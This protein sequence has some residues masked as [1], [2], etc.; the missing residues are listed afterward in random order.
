MTSE[1][2]TSPLISKAYTYLEDG[3][4]NSANHLI[5]TYL[6]RHPEDGQAHHMAGLCRDALGDRE[7][8]RHH[9]EQSVALSPAETGP[10]IQLFMFLA[11]DDD[12]DSAL[13][14]VEKALRH[15]P[16]NAR[17]LQARSNAQRQLGDIKG[18][19]TTANMA[20][21][22]K[23]S[24]AYAHYTLGMSLT[25]ARLYKE[26][27]DAFRSAVELDST[28]ADAWTNLGVVEKE[29]GD[30][31]AATLSYENALTL[32]PNDPIIHNNQGNMLLACGDVSSAMSAYRR[33]VELKPD[34]VDAKVNLALAYREQGDPEHA[35]KYLEEIDREH[36]NEASVLNSL[37]NALRHAERFEEARTALECAINLSPDHAEAHNNLGLVMALLGRRDE[38]RTFFSK[39]EKL[40]PDL[41]VFANN[42][43]TLLLKMFHLDDAILAL[44]RAVLLDP[45][46]CDAW[47]NLGVAHFMCGH[48][49]EAVDAYRK[50]I[51]QQPDNT[52]AHYSLGV[53]LIEQQ[54]LSEGT[55]EI[56]R[57]LELNPNNVM[58]LNT[59]G[60]ALLD[61]HCIDDARAAMKTAAES[62]T[63]SAPVYASNYLFTS[64][65]SPDV[66][67]QQI[68]EE[69]SAF[70]KRFTS[71]TPDRNY[72]HLN[73]SNPDRKLKLAYLSP[74]FRSHSV[75]FFIEPLLEKHDRNA[76]EIILYSN[77]T[78]QDVVTQAMQGAA[79]VWVET[80]GLTDQNLVERIRADRV[81]ILV[82]LGGHTSGN[83]LVACGQKPVPIQIQYL[84]Y[85]NTSGVQAMDY[86]LSDERADPTG[87][88]KVFCTETIIRLPDCFHC[89][90]P[91]SRA[92][93]PASA[94]HVER[95]FV[96][97]G[98]FN[99]LP[100][101]NTEVVN[102]WSEILTQVPNSR[103]YL[104]CK[105]LKTE[106]VRDRVMGYF[107]D[108]GIDKSRIDMDAFMPS[109]QEH[110]NQYARIDL[111]LDT[112]PYN[113]TTTTCEALWMGVPV[114]SV[115]GTRHTG[116]V[117]L[118]L[119]HAAGLSEEFIAKDLK[120]YIQKA[121]SWGHS[122]QRLAEVRSTL[123][124][125]LS[126]S[127][128]RDEIRF[129]RNLERVYRD[130]WRQW[131][132]GPQQTYEHK[133]P[134]PL[135]A[136]DSVQSVLGKTL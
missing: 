1:T 59:L 14:I 60:V 135:R 120:T 77:T 97:F 100:K 22:F 62:D 53:A 49:E 19:I 65:Y 90:R 63:M 71:N 68:F 106:S 112:F 10:A 34:Y 125:Q 86:R 3:D 107:V 128:L 136:D 110:L 38:A 87:E 74:D 17:L 44:E 124:Q 28:F 54:D 57:A 31:A 42:H 117:G 37:G 118:S 133:A 129:T 108:R 116:R 27:K 15:Q 18:A 76:F 67:D 98:S 36:P 115:N 69:H 105:Q 39:A 23:P 70:G 48:Y 119:L 25:M 114:L 109:I 45:T 5:Q 11:E 131:C 96:T 83:R 29:C 21:A 103:L 88:A 72:P 126:Q 122:P 13:S 80:A 132:E 40:R 104:K 2:V 81:D 55:A 79:D 78:R 89:Y 64:L 46:Y 24:D 43:G 20:I 52:F 121:V 56:E 123:R 85:P 127:P 91:T 33:A 30:L 99:V 111:A 94:P 134:L 102:A 130:L 95:G 12:F 32:Q 75:A 26:A 92:P 8:A 73:D 7:G 41:P 93:E 35:L 66:D 9:L 47:V 50:V 84:G 82:D 4:A 6:D 16:G 51:L 61:Q 113:G 58:A 101:L